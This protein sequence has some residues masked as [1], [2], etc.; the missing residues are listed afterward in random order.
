MQ[1]LLEAANATDTERSRFLTMLGNF[2]MG[3]RELMDV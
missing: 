1:P 3:Y 2:R